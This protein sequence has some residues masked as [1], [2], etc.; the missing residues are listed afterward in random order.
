MGNGNTGVSHLSVSSYF[1]G[2][3]Q[4]EVCDETREARVQSVV[5]YTVQSAVLLGD[6]AKRTCVERGVDADA[7]SAA[8]YRNLAAKGIAGPTDG[9]CRSVAVCR[10]NRLAVASYGADALSAV[11]HPQCLRVERRHRRHNRP[12]QQ[13]NFS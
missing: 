4:R 8:V 9:T 1:E 11:V 3:V 5:E 10:D 12:Y 13:K 6:R 7:G 2:Y